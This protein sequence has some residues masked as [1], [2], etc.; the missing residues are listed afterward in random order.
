MWLADPPP[1][2]LAY[3]II[4]HNFLSQASGCYR[5]YLPLPDQDWSCYHP[6]C[7]VHPSQDRPLAVVAQL[8]LNYSSSRPEPRL[9]LSIH[10]SQERLMAMVVLLLSCHRPYLP[11]SDPDWGCYC[12]INNVHK[13]PPS[14]GK[15]LLSSCLYC[16]CL[17]S[18]ARTMAVIGTPT[19]NSNTNDIKPN[20]IKQND[21]NPN[22]IYSTATLSRTTLSWMTYCIP[23]GEINF[24]PTMT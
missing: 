13:I 11:F 17:T 23:D 15:W 19:L 4:V 21:I 10:P 22:A 18:Q 6:Y 5:P 8:S 24:N 3:P 1:W 12:P 9:F 2:K 7:T 14:P 20:N 16:P